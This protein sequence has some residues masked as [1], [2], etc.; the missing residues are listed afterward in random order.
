LGGPAQAPRESAAKRGYG[1]SWQKARA[2]FLAENPLCV[3]CTAQGRVTGATEVDHI[4]PHRR[5]VRLFWDPS[6]W[7]PLCKPCHSRKTASEDMPRG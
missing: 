6:N 4:R 2:D 5:N 1:R 3:L 7:Q